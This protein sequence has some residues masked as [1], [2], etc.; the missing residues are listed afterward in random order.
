MRDLG[1]YALTEL[2][3]GSNVRGIQTTATYDIEAKEF[4][5]NT[6]ADIDQKFWIGALGKMAFRAVV[7]A[8]LWTKGKCYG[9]HCFWMTIR[10]PRNHRVLPG[11]EI[12][13]CGEKLGLNG[14][15]NGWMKF[16]DFRVERDALLDRFGSVDD[17]GNYSSPIKSDGKRFAISIASLTGGRVG[18]VRITQDNALAGLSIATRFSCIRRQFPELGSNDQ[19]KEVLIMDYPLQQYR[20][21]TRTAE[22]IITFVG[23]QKLTQK[24]IKNLP[25][26]YDENNEEVQVCHALSSAC[27]SFASWSAQETLAECRKSMGGLG[28]S[29]YSLIG[30]IMYNGDVNQTY[31]GDNNVLIMQT[32]KFLVKNYKLY[33]K[34]K[35]FMSTCEFLAEPEISGQQDKTDLPILVKLFSQ[36]ARDVLAKF[37]GFLDSKKATF[38]ELGV[39]YIK[40]LSQIYFYNFIITAFVEFM[41]EHVTDDKVRA[42]FE[43]NLVLFMKTKILAEGAYFRQFFDTSQFDQLKEDVTQLLAELRP[44]A[45]AITDMFPI[46]N[47][48]LGPFGNE[49]LQGYDRFLNHVYSQ[50]GVR[51]RADWGQIVYKNTDKA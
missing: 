3:H 40:E 25:R 29:H 43:R 42:M 27:K 7:Y 46:A 34:S 14:M 30:W 19:T 36:R 49:D 38:E 1:C 31:E 9:V 41:D 28:Y 11:L 10:D 51:E 47:R 5:I 17:L 8:Q 21:F 22:A 2:G 23:A 26:L 50:K 35:K 48:M 45:I 6:P 12:G 32:V 18:F 15:D 33:S 13:Q 44:D 4:I 24:W 20:L 37:C 16:H 39:H